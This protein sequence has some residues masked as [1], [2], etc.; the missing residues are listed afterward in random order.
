MPL[1]IVASPANWTNCPAPAAVVAKVRFPTFRAANCA[2][3]LEFRVRDPIALVLPTAPETV[4]VPPVPMDSAP[5]PIKA[6]STSPDRA[7]VPEPDTNPRMDPVERVTA[8]WS[9]INPPVVVMEDVPLKTISPIV[10]LAKFEVETEPRSSVA[11]PDL[12]RPPWKAN[13]SVSWF[14]SVTVPV[15]NSVACPDTVMSDCQKI[16]PAPEAA[17]SVSAVT[18]PAKVTPPAWLEV[19]VRVVAF[20]TLVNETAPWLST[21]VNGPANDVPRAPTVA[22]DASTILNP[23]RVSAIEASASTPAASSDKALATEATAPTV[24]PDPETM[25]TAEVSVAAPSSAVSP[26]LNKPARVR[27]ELALAVR[28]AAKLNESAAESPKV[29]APVLAKVTEAESTVVSA[30]NRRA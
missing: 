1:L 23:P 27:L 2:P 11:P 24:N 8:P 17:D 3:A 9:A 19:S 30:S 28:P 10:I 25:L 4:T 15:V 7:I 12:P 5:A 18:D 22:V 20:T 16:S 29:R 14:P 6:P 13:A 21:S 26:A